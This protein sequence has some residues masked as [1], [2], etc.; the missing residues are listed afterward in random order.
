MDVTALRP[1]SGNWLI[2]ATFAVFLLAGAGSAANATNT[3]SAPQS[4]PHRLVLSNDLI[5]A[6]AQDGNTVAWINSR[7]DLYRVRARNVATGKSFVLGDANDYRARLRPP[8]LAVAGTRVFWTTCWYGT[9]LY[10]DGH[11]TTLAERSERPQPKPVLLFELAQ[12]S[13]N[14]ADGY[15]AGAAGDGS[16]LAYG[17][18]HVSPVG[19]PSMERVVDGGGVVR[20]QGPFTTHFPPAAPPISNLPVAAPMYSNDGRQQLARQLAVSQGRVAVLPPSSSAGRYSWAV[21]RP[22]EDGPVTV[23]TR[24]GTVI[25]RVTPAGTVG[26]IALAWPNLA[27]LVQRHDGT[28]AVEVYDASNGLR[29]SA[30]AVPAD[31]SDLSIGT[32]GLVYRVGRSIYTIGAGGPRL[33]WRAQVTPIGLSVEGN[34]VAWAAN[35]GGRGRIV[36]LTLP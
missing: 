29:K 31:A 6:F 32:G 5:Q 1:S 17:W 34:R 10:I 3:P 14:G 4:K 2:A 15:F 7:R 8:T 12:D 30:T 24:G 11:T 21:P 25:S 26:G 35:V 22:A 20:V 9:R 19:E 36:A 33:L 13:D 23:S 18:T 28:K 16:T 27:V